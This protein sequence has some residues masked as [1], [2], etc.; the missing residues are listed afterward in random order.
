MC[1][2]SCRIL[3]NRAI[4]G[5]T[6]H[7]A[8][9]SLNLTLNTGTIRRSGCRCTME[10]ACHSLNA[11]KKSLSLFIKL[12]LDGDACN[13]TNNV[14][15]AR[16]IAKPCIPGGIVAPKTPPRG[17]KSNTNPHEPICMARTLAMRPLR[18][19]TSVPGRALAGLQ[20]TVKL[21]LHLSGIA[22]NTA[23]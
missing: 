17:Q 15:C 23:G 13:K 5:T 10:G 18:P 14:H 2:R 9:L 8:M 20:M 19:L 3:I 7:E 16:G 4:L 11:E 6:C 12:H 22:C 1:L 21:S